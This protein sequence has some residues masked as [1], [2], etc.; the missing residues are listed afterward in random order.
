MLS[1]SNCVRPLTSVI[2][3][4]RLTVSLP[5]TIVELTSLAFSIEP[6]SCALDTPSAL[7][8]TAPVVTVKSVLANDATPLL[9]SVASSASMV[10]VPALSL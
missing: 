8:P 10:N 7:I 3:S 6:A 9:E 2:V 5:N 1:T 4:P